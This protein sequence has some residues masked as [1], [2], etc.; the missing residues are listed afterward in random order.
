MTS[1][2]FFLFSFSFCFYLDLRQSREHTLVI[3]GQAVNRKAISSSLSLC[4]LML[5]G[6]RLSSL[7][8]TVHWGPN[9]LPEARA[10][11]LM[12]LLSVNGYCDQR[13]V[14]VHLAEGL[15]NGWPYCCVFQ[16]SRRHPSGAPRPWDPSRS[17]GVSHQA[18]LA[19][20]TALLFHWGP[21]SDSQRK[22]TCVQNCL[23]SA[24]QQHAGMILL[25]MSCFYK[26]SEQS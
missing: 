8:V 19:H 3:I 17:S 12:R 23:C 21:D 22:R 24:H 7:H 6:P 10:E 20:T 2:C 18:T 26:A 11:Y 9:E 1:A 16:P 25:G 15:Y 13:R 14:P 5:A 4:P